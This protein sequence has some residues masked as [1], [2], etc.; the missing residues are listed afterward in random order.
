[1][2]S[3]RTTIPAPTT[4]SEINQR[5]AEITVEGQERIAALPID[6]LEALGEALLDFTDLADLNAWLAEH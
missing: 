3:G 2:H 5:Y 4:R 6:Q 1:M